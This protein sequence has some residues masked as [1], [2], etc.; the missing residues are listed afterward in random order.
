MASERRVY[1]RSTL[2]GLPLV[3]RLRDMCM[4]LSFDPAWIAAVDAL[5]SDLK[6]AFT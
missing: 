5:V 6:A 1:G 4:W 2:Y 3:P